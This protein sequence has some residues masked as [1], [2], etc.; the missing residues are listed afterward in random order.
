M[1]RQSTDL[2]D[3]LAH[4]RINRLL[5]SPRIRAQE[6]AKFIADEAGLDISTL[7]SFRERNGYGVLT[8]MTKT[9]AK[10][11]YPEQVEALKDIHYGVD[12]AE[13]YQLIQARII[14]AL[15]QAS[16]DNAAG[17]TAIVTHGGPIRLIYRD[18]LK[19]G[20]IDVDDCAYTVITRD[21]ETYKLLEHYGITLK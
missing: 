6:T 9:E 8:G 20:E 4:K 13:E 18:I 21:G 12:G 19:L 7:D 2:A 3:T 17:V 1:T 11:K 14:N 15:D 10:A 16:R 5:V